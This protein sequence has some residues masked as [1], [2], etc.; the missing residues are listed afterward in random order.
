MEDLKTKIDNLSVKFDQDKTE[1]S[2]KIIFSALNDLRNDSDLI[3]IENIVLLI[4]QCIVLDTLNVDNI[5]IDEKVFTRNSIVEEIKI[6]YEE[7][8]LSSVIDEWENDLNIALKEQISYLISLILYKVHNYTEA[9]DYFVESRKFSGNLKNAEIMGLSLLQRI[10]RDIFFSYCCEYIGTPQMNC[11]KLV[12]SLQVLL[13]VKEKTKDANEYWQQLKNYCYDHIA[14]LDVILSSKSPIQDKTLELIKLLLQFSEDECSVFKRLIKMRKG[15]AAVEDEYNEA[16]HVL[17]HCLNELN[18]FFSNSNVEPEINQ[19]SNEA[20]EHLK[21]R[22]IIKMIARLCIDSLGDKYGTCQATIRAEQGN[23]VDAILRMHNMDSSKLN[24][25]DRAELDFYQYYFESIFS[26]QNHDKNHK[27]GSL[28]YDVCKQNYETNPDNYQDGLLHYYIVLFKNQLKLFLDE[29][30]NSTDK[31]EA[32][33][34][35][36]KKIYNNVCFSSYEELRK[37]EFSQ[38]V[39][40]QMIFERKKL[41]T[42]YKIL[43][44]FQSCK[45][46]LFYESEN[47]NKK[48]DIDE[49]IEEIYNLC[50]KFNEYSKSNISTLERNYKSCYFCEQTE[51]C[52]NSKKHTSNIKNEDN[53]IQYGIPVLVDG[54]T[55]EFYGNIRKFKEYLDKYLFTTYMIMDSDDIKKNKM[56]LESKLLFFDN[57]DENFECCQELCRNMSVG[58]IRIFYVGDPDEDFEFNTIAAFKSIN[59]C[60]LMAYIYKSIERI[61]DYI[62]KPKPIYI[63]APLRNVSNYEFQEAK[64][65]SLLK[66]PPNYIQSIEV[67]SGGIGIQY[68]KEKMEEEYFKVDFQNIDIKIACV[69]IVKL[70]EDKLYVLRGKKLVHKNVHI[71]LINEMY[72][73][74]ANARKAAEDKRHSPC[75]GEDCRAVKCSYFYKPISDDKVFSRKKQEAAKKLIH[76]LY[77]ACEEHIPFIDKCYLLQA[78]FVKERRTEG[79]GF[80]IYIF[81]KDIVGFVQKQCCF[82]KIVTLTKVDIG[83]EDEETDEEKDETE[84]S[85]IDKVRKRINDFIVECEGTIEDFK[86][87]EYDKSIPKV[88]SIISEAK[89]LLKRMTDKKNVDMENIECELINLRKKMNRVK[90]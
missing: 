61:L 51:K 20:M 78:S 46:P 58:G 44:N 79:N 59:M 39:S 23:G 83:S 53:E 4:N 70:Y 36:D 74:Y 6:F 14:D 18:L 88:K 26:Y 40:I 64:F 38:F 9:Y 17:A 67:D 8:V 12:T 76:L 55:F 80:E 10:K 29:I 24:M 37:H 81:D 73:E 68:K 1:D 41:I 32:F 50:K 85:K 48:L 31:N 77:I 65:D 62:F 42:I 56:D 30:I 82:G 72:D 87:D 66:F 60:F 21:K 90:S 11:E 13:G 63:L 33:F 54:L 22:N 28:F 16:I 27:H 71:G 43:R 15:G 57:S 89:E 25:L 52:N 2:L 5:K 45:L 7:F 3:F 75:V 47:F 35:E 49:K 69:G 19:N 34:K 86:V 84:N